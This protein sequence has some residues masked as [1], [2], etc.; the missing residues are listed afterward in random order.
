MGKAT[1]LV[2]LHSLPLQQKD[3]GF[4]YYNG[5]KTF[6]A[7][8]VAKAMTQRIH[9]QRS[10]PRRYRCEKKTVQL[11]A[12]LSLWFKAFPENVK[13]LQS[14]RDKNYLKYYSLLPWLLCVKPKT[15]DICTGGA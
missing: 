5:S 12:F 9:S 7:K 3:K 6:H 13:V 14:L 10:L 1:I 4:L 8:Y 2:F 15:H 11:C